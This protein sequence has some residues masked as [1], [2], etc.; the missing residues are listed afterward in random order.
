MNGVMRSSRRHESSHAI[1]FVGTGSPITGDA[2]ADLF[3]CQRTATEVGITGK[4]VDSVVFAAFIRLKTVP[5]PKTEF[6]IAEQP[7]KHLVAEKCRQ[8][9]REGRTGRGFSP[10]LLKAR[11]EMCSGGRQMRPTLDCA[12]IDEIAQMPRAMA[13]CWHPDHPPL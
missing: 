8:L 11:T 6:D 3:V 1:G 4:L 5:R 9:A 2:D 10:R 7:A 13:S 12:N